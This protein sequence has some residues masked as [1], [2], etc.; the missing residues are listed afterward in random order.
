MTEDVRTRALSLIAAMS[1]N[2]SD[3]E[4]RSLLCD[5]HRMMGPG[6]SFEACIV[7]VMSLMCAVCVTEQNFMDREKAQQARDLRES[8]CR[9]L[10]K[11]LQ[12]GRSAAPEITAEFLGVLPEGEWNRIAKEMLGGV[13][14][15]G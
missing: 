15:K 12:V 8:M 10:E 7:A 1:V 3:A 5:A 9:A 2:A 4:K 11:V 13:D 14:T 6:V